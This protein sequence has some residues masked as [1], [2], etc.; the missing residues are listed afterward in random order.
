MTES[1]K[2]HSFVTKPGEGAGLQNSLSQLPSGPSLWAAEGPVPWRGVELVCLRV[3]RVQPGGNPGGRW[4][5]LDP[6]HTQCLPRKFPVVPGP[7]G[8]SV[9]GLQPQTGPRA[10]WAELGPEGSGRNFYGPSFWWPHIPPCPP[11]C[12]GSSPCISP[13]CLLRSPHPVGAPRLDPTLVTPAENRRAH[14]LWRHRSAHSKADPLCLGSLT[15]PQRRAQKSPQ[16]S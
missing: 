4:G 6:A 13:L 11:T 10:V 16:A 7:I 8:A 15:G 12:Q 5:C 14:P 2:S 3:C 1:G 9:G